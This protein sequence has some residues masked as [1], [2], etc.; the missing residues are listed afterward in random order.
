MSWWNEWV[1][2]L[3]QRLQGLSIY[4]GSI[5]GYYGEDTD[6][7][8]RQLRVNAGVG[9]EEMVSAQTWQALAEQ[10]RMAGIDAYGEQ[11]A[12][13]DIGAVDVD[14]SENLVGQVSEDGQWRWDGSEWQPAAAEQPDVVEGSGNA[15]EAGVLSEDGQWRWDGSQWQPAHDQ[16]GEIPDAEQTGDDERREIVVN[17]GV[18]DWSTDE[19]ELL[20]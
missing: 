14:R 16:G 18:D 12:G 15:T 8:V 11:D 7:A 20:V 13:Q 9:D 2:H 5:D 6:A 19:A 1:T 17:D 4:D 10:E 3:Q